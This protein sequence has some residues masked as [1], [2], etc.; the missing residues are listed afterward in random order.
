MEIDKAL[1]Q[2]EEI[3]SH[4]QRSELYRGYRSILTAAMG[5]VALGAAFLQPRFVV[6][7]HPLSFVYF[8][9]AV[10]L[11]NFLLPISQILFHYAA[12]ESPLERKKTRLA[13]GQFLPCLLA[14]AFL[15]IAVCKTNE[16]FI[17]FLPGLWSILFAMGVYASKPYLPGAI[18]WMALSFFLGGVILLALVPSGQSLSPWGMG[19]D[20]SLGLLAG[21]GILYFNLERKKS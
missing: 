14:G 11:A 17:I 9:V 16:N 12:Y 13:V 3:H 5:L 2:L 10:A 4:V 19:L 21:A 6:L 15:T 18:H 7:E 20:F 1:E 8:W